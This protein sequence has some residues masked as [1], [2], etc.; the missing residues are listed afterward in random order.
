[1]ICVYTDNYADADDV[2]RVE[3]ELRSLGINDV[4]YY[5]PDI[6]TYFGIYANNPYKIKASVYASKG[7]RV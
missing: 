1:M 3:R 4:L 6:Y 7:P 2:M 5:K